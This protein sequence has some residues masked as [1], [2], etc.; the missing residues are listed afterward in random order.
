MFEKEGEMYKRIFNFLIFLF[1]A[2]LLISYSSLFSYTQQGSKIEKTNDIDVISNPKNPIP[3][4]GL[5]KRIVFEEDLSIG[6]VEGD[7]NYMF[8]NR[9]YFNVDEEGNFYVNDWDRKRI[10]KFDPQGKYLLSIG[11]AGQ[12]PGEFRNVWIPRFDKDKNL[13]VSDI[14][15]RRISFFDKEGKF[16]RQI[17]IP[18]HLSNV[19]VNSKGFFVG[20]QTTNID[21]PSGDKS[22]FILG[23][24]DERFNL[25][26]EFHR[27]IWESKR[28]SGRDAESRAQFLANLLGDDAF[29]PSMSYVLAEND[30]IY[31]GYPEKYEIR[32]YSPEGKLVKIIQRDYDPIRV[33]KK[34]KESFIQYQEDEFFRFIE[35]PENIKKK[36]YQLIKYPKYIPAYQRFTLME[37]GWLAVIV[38]SIEDEY[39]LMDIFDKDGKYIAQFKTTVPPGNLFFK[40]GKAYALAT[41]TESGFRFVKRYNFEIQEYKDNKWIRDK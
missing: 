16:L 14:V 32:V 29:K 34:H 8:G 31:F 9:V 22:I 28:S 2:I 7:E 41:E 18:I 15:S 23:L 37:N 26:A 10:K 27:Q 20:Y 35:T 6:E 5:K 11:R 12:G 21:D 3:K 40:D 19:Y 24:Y 38:D 30:F 33:S 36:V 13:Y 25:I 39:T 4:D 17:R 1:Y